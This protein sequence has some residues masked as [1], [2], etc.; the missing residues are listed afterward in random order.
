MYSLKSAMP[1]QSSASHSHSAVRSGS[2][3][4]D[5]SGR[6]LTQLA[7]SSSSPRAAPG[8]GMHVRKNVLRKFARMVSQKQKKGLSSKYRLVQ[9]KRQNSEYACLALAVC[10]L[11]GPPFTA[12][13]PRQQTSP[14]D[15]TKNQ[16]IQK[17]ITAQKK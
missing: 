6:W 11:Y 2:S 12:A 5:G 7:P 4:C 15:S 16:R 3:S 9:W 13:T 1:S 14:P 17:P 8:D 10:G